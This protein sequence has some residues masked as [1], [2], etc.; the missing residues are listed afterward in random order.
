MNPVVGAS[1]GEVDEVTLSVDPLGA[2]PGVYVGTLAIYSTAAAN[3]PQLV[4]VTFTL[5]A[6]ANT[7]VPTGTITPTYTSSATA[8]PTASPTATPPPGEG[9]TPTW[10]WPVIGA[11]VGISA[12]LAGIA[13]ATSGLLGKMFRRGGGEGEGLPYEDMYEGEYGEPGGDSGD[14]TDEEI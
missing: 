2:T 7:T 8:T 10:V 14:D 1:T 4:S 12:V 6:A 13:L 5:R 11:L 9:G 3:S